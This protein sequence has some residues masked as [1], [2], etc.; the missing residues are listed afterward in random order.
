M[1]SDSVPS[2]LQSGARAT[3]VAALYSDALISDREYL[4]TF[5]PNHDF[6]IF[7]DGIDTSFPFH[8]HHMA[9]TLFL[10]FTVEIRTGNPEKFVKIPTFVAPIQRNASL[11][12]SYLVKIDR[13][14]EIGNAYT[15]TFFETRCPGHD[16][17][18]TQDS[19]NCHRCPAGA[20]CRQG[21]FLGGKQNGSVWIPIDGMMRLVDCP[22]GF[23]LVR[24]EANP[25]KDE[26]V[27]CPDDT[28]IDK[29][30]D[31]ATGFLVTDD[32]ANATSMCKACF[33]GFYCYAGWETHPI[34]WQIFPANRTQDG[35]IVMAQVCLDRMQ[36]C[37]LQQYGRVFSYIVVD[38]E[39]EEKLESP[40]RRGADLSWVVHSY[41]DMAYGKSI[42]RKITEDLK[43]QIIS[44]VNEG[45]LKSQR[46]DAER[47]QRRDLP[48]ALFVEVFPIV[49]E[50]E[51]T[52]KGQGAWVFEVL[53]DNV[54]LQ[55]SP[56]ILSV[57]P[58]E[59]EGDNRV[60]DGSGYC[61]CGPG[62][63]DF[64][65]IC[66]STFVLI[67][68]IVV[69]VVSIVGIINFVYGYIRFVN[70]YRNQHTA[71][72]LFTNPLREGMPL[73]FFTYQ[74]RLPP[75]NGPISNSR[76][77]CPHWS[78]RHMRMLREDL[79]RIEPEEIN[80]SDVPKVLG[81]GSF[82]WVV[83]AQYRGTAVAV[84]RLYIPGMKKRPGRT[85]A[86]VGKS[87]EFPVPNLTRPLRVS[88]IFGEPG[89]A[90]EHK[91]HASN[92]LTPCAFSYC[93]FE[94]GET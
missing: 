64:A 11:P 53:A 21:H 87:C 59:C 1:T 34:R 38:F 56:F 22:L 20:T 39:P 51:F 32:P 45:Q 46:R 62:F 49:Y 71:L 63:T 86:S 18:I 74:M 44:Y 48:S 43:Q 28:F 55:N 68:C 85:E 29:K 8:H 82:G 91:G 81:Q 24:D 50:M 60:D 15:E 23:I 40:T 76:Y 92:A 6:K 77:P 42:Q 93:C 57:L 88:P 84:K 19:F 72:H 41:P 33:L 61:V 13:E 27:I 90:L 9:K 65:G 17:S 7:L 36:T 89:K 94:S 80:F 35:D 58:I 37:S 14:L 12:G 5:S 2:L 25:A 70:R 30:P 10:F 78:H 54:Q 67:I 3:E 75:A 66:V 4:F 79:W 16:Y 31:Y 26:C 47:L 83:K 52:V 69:P 73:L